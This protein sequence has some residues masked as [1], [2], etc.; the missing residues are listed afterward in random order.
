[1]IIEIMEE[2]ES[3]LDS[4]GESTR[5]VYS[6]YLYDLFKRYNNA[7]FKTINP[8]FLIEFVNETFDSD[9]QKQSALSSMAGFLRHINHKDLVYNDKIKRHF[10]P[11][12]GNEIKKLSKK[13]KEAVVVKEPEFPTSKE[14]REK[15][16]T[17]PEAEA[18]EIRDKI[19]L[20]LFINYPPMRADLVYVLREDYDEDNI[21]INERIKTSGETNLKLNKDTT[22][23][24]DKYLSMH[25]S[26]FLLDFRRWKCER[27]EMN[28]KANEAFSKHLARITKSI[29]GVKITINDFRKLYVEQ[30]EKDLEGKNSREAQL[31]RIETANKMGH[32]IKTRAIH[33]DVL[34]RE[35][36]EK[37]ITE[38]KE[39][40][41]EDIEKLIEEAKKE[42]LRL[43]FEEV[44]LENELIKQR[45]SK[46]NK[47]LNQ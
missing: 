22:E 29:F 25:N 35:E 27:T 46:L 14:L 8:E 11:I 21:H 19:I 31:E 20:D 32:S 37:E 6:R 7:D 3:Y 42:K 18:D 15:V 10:I 28:S 41:E 4:L 13:I 12:I 23:L 16:E 2:I 17:L 43:E 34:K 40:K 47:Q 38:E 5:H 26:P 33:Y 36:E 24:I 1:M 44:K 45:I 30:E 39:E 9:N